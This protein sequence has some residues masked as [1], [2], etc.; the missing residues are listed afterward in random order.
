M[1]D[2]KIDE[3]LGSNY[4]ISLSGVMIGYIL[5]LLA[6]RQHEL[7]KSLKDDAFDPMNA[8][9][10]ATND[11]VGNTLLHEVYASCGAGFLAFVMQTGEK[12]MKDLMESKGPENIK[13]AAKAI[14][15]S[16]DKTLN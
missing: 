9:L 3:M 14:K 5:K 10:A 13:K 15:R 6:D 11:T 4:T 2:Q 7:N 1:N 16:Q 8:I 12:E